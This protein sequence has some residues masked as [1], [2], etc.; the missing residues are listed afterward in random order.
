MTHRE[1]HICAPTPRRRTLATRT[2]ATRTFATRTFA[3]R[4]TSR[5]VRGRVALRARPPLL[6]RGGLVL[7][8]AGFERPARFVA[9]VLEE[10]LDRVQHLGLEVGP[11]VRGRVHRHD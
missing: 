1:T 11:C 5:R 10:M 6:H 2:L 4:R 9:V 7:E 8:A 3:T